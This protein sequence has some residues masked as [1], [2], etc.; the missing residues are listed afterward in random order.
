M[1]TQISI[2]LKSL[3]T[4]EK[5]KGNLYYKDFVQKCLC[6]CLEQKKDELASNCSCFRYF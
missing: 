4:L 2:S 3:K 6:T 1:V 5:M